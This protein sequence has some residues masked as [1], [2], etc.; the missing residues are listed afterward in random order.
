MMLA[1]DS[2]QDIELFGVDENLK[3]EN[4]ERKK[5]T[6]TKTFQMLHL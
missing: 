5:R 2:R 4:G 3:M 6:A 1:S